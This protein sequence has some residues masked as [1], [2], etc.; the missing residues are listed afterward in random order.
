M[1]YCEQKDYSGDT[2]VNKTVF[3][4]IHLPKPTFNVDFKYVLAI[5]SIAFYA[6]WQ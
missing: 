5:I 2:P 3:L 6:G 4:Q 1:D